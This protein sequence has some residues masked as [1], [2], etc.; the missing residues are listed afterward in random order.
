MKTVAEEVNER[1]MCGIE[2]RLKKSP[3]YYGLN[4]FNQVYHDPRLTSN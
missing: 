1:E 2:S 4:E 3:T